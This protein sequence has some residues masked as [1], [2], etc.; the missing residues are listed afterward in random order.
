MHVP[1]NSLIVNGQQH[2]EYAYGVEKRIPAK[3]PPVEI[4]HG[5]GRQTADGYDEHDV[6][7]RRSDDAAHADV[8]FGQKNTDDHG[9]QLGRRT[10]GRHKSCASD[11]WAHPEF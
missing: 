4:G 1:R 2:D 5:A 6:E 10:T 8:V 7:N 9:G 3:G 11:I